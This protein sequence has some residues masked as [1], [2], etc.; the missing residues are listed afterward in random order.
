MFH[1]LDRK[2]PGSRFI[3]AVRDE[4][5][6]LLPQRAEEAR[7]AISENERDPACSLW[8]SVPGRGDDQLIARVRFHNG[9]VIDR[10]RT[11]PDALLV[12][13]WEKG[14]GGPNSAASLEAR[15]LRPA[16]LTRTKGSIASPQISAAACDTTCGFA[17]RCTSVCPGER[18]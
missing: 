5:R 9:I 3:L 4:E 16:S 14:R 12:V 7:R 11:R 10:F 15:S 18:S 13:D 8:A 6:W 17:R 2:Y 1:K